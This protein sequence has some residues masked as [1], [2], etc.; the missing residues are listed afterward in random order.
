MEPQSGSSG[1]LEFEES[2]HKQKKTSSFSKYEQPSELP[3][4]APFPARH[5]WTKCWRLRNAAQVSNEAPKTRFKIDA[6]I[7]DDPFP[8]GRMVLDWGV[9]AC[10]IHVK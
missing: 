5:S 3:R 2:R 6:L 7:G 9:N 8:A 1:L 10:S 4:S